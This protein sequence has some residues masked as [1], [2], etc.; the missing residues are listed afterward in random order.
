[1]Q[2]N[3]GKNLMSFL[4]LNVNLT[5]IHLRLTK[6]NIFELPKYPSCQN[7]PIEDREWKLFIQMLKVFNPNYT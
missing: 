6:K 2:L 5:F 3:F 4:Y 7:I 1:M